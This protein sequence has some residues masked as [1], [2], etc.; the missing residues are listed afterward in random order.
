LNQQS[1]SS[2]LLD[3]AV[4]ELSKLPGI[5]KKTAL[6][7]ALH[8][9]KQ[10]ES[11]VESLGVALIEVRKKISY[12]SVC[13][14]ISDT[15]ICSICSN[16][17]R[18]NELVCVVENI[19]D[20]IS[21]EN[22]Q[23]FRG[24]Y[25]VLGGIISPVEGIGPHDLEIESLVQKAENGKIKEII[26]ALSATMEGD[27]TGF[28]IYRKIS[29]TGLKITSIAR[30]VAVGDSLEYADEITLGQSI[31]NRINYKYQ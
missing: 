29:H 10:P 19:K 6:R 14:N 26:L 16:P 2:G 1:L 24:L 27:T 23:Q 15:E 20:V 21:I 12:C 11:E 4:N 31:V 30:G 25:H 17:Q 18:D 3:N 9:L 7:L 8:L 13:H 22:T 28:Y 5:G